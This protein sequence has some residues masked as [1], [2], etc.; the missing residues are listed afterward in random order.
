MKKGLVYT[1]FFK[2]STRRIIVLMVW[3]II[4]KIFILYLCFYVLSYPQIMHHVTVSGCYIET[5]KDGKVMV[6][7]SENYRNVSMIPLVPNGKMTIV[8]QKYE[9]YSCSG[10]IK[11]VD[12]DRIVITIA[13]SEY[14]DEISSEVPVSL[15]FRYANRNILQRSM[16]KILGGMRKR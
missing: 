10:L 2:L 8:W 9:K 3:A 15:F 4:V 7:P 13:P 11:Q 12:D 1:I 6:I 14:I 16:D 5:D